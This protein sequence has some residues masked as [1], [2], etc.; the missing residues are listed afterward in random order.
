MSES[1]PSVSGGFLFPGIVAA[2]A[3]IIGYFAYAPSLES[4]RPNEWPAETPAKHDSDSVLTVA[5]RLWEDPLGAVDQESVDDQTKPPGGQP[6]N[7]T[8]R[9]DFNEL[10]QANNQ[11]PVLVLPILLNGGR[12]PDAKE[13]RMRSR[14][15]VLAGL[16]TAKYHPVNSTKLKHFRVQGRVWPEDLLVPFEQFLPDE[17][18]PLYD[19][20]DDPH[21]STVTVCWVDEDRLGEQPLQALTELIQNLYQPLLCNPP[22]GLLS[23]QVRILGPSA[24]EMLLTMACEYAKRVKSAG[25]PGTLL[26]P[27]ANP[28][29]VDAR[30]YSCRAT[31][32]PAALKSFIE[33]PVKTFTGRETWVGDNKFEPRRSGAPPI[34]NVIGTDWHLA[35]ALRKELKV[36][37][38]WPDAHVPNQCIV[39]LTEMD[40]AYGRSIPYLFSRLLN[41]A[42]NGVELTVVRGASSGLTLQLRGSSVE[43]PAALAGAT[44]QIVGNSEEPNAVDQFILQVDG[45]ERQVL[46]AEAHI[47]KKSGA[48]LEMEWALSWPEVATLR[49]GRIEAAL[50]R[51]ADGRWDGEGTWTFAEPFVVFRY[52]RGI[53][54]KPAKREEANNRTPAARRGDSLAESPPSDADIGWSPTGNSQRDYLRR[55]EHELMRLHA[56]QKRAGGKGIRAIGVV[57]TDVYDKLLILRA[58]RRSFPN[59]CFFTTDLDAELVLP[60]ELPHTRN[61]IVA[62][63]FGL[64]LEPRLQRDVPPFR[65]S[66]QTST[67]LSALL[68][69]HDDRTWRVVEAMSHRRTNY[70]GASA[71]PSEGR[72]PDFWPSPVIDP[73]N[74]QRRIDA[75][76]SGKQAPGLIEWLDQDPWQ[77][78]GNSPLDG[79]LPKTT[80]KSPAEMGMLK[81][82]YL[83]PLIFE[84]GRHLPYQLT[85]THPTRP[86][87]FALP[88][89]P[90]NETTFSALVHPASPRELQ[91]FP[92]TMWSALG[93]VLIL[94]AVFLSLSLT[95]VRRFFNA[96]LDAMLSA[97]WFTL[98]VVPLT[99]AW[100][101]HLLWDCPL[102]PLPESQAGQPAS[103]RERGIMSARELWK[104]YCC[105]LLRPGSVF[106]AASQRD[107]HSL[108]PR[109]AIAFST[110]L[111]GCFGWFV[112]SEHCI[113]P[114]GEPF[115]LWM[116]ISVWPSTI[117]RIVVC[118]LSATLL[119]TGVRSLRKDAQQ[120]LE[121]IKQY[122]LR[123]R[124]W[125]RLFKRSPQVVWY[126]LCVFRWKWEEDARRE[127]RT[128][129]KQLI[130]EPWGRRL[131]KK[132]GLAWREFR[133]FLWSWN[134]S[135]RGKEEG[136]G[137]RK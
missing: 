57:G 21:Y 124:N 65:N 133:V 56:E 88:S 16:A 93:V 76:K 24:S 4:R 72:D 74:L 5:S 50:R 102:A 132:T 121:G 62:S 11:R 43:R 137:A 84:I 126:R 131:R 63:H 13:L 110:V 29:P 85:L 118:I 130:T 45:D 129:T 109:A 79:Y 12:G 75:A 105:R 55:L 92:V 46:C 19:S 87:S 47:R 95:F 86:S 113:N 1:K 128:R 99:V 108:W 32:E 122:P 125:Y 42:D 127:R 69:L 134:E 51:G 7:P 31:V 66:Y 60:S 28:F 136:R 20:H 10:E 78:V 27:F 44:V 38:V 114:D 54:G 18:D 30:M 112:Y 59:V 26:P 71:G 58:I 82:T 98:S 22:P 33:D 9:L 90:G 68:A 83:E 70:P 117:I 36:R 115:E 8:V 61:L 14:Y 96:V 89:P 106:F 40:S 64:S 2:A 94:S 123:V 23:A 48:T 34:T 37:G 119:F 100:Y 52:L 35:H 120:A 80:P 73:I 49:S 97:V 77:Q 111:L 53:D 3:A 17:T 41:P 101:L 91:K 107:K 104:A 103:A 15:A 116:G 135:K 39:L 67:F 25:A 81:S 6:T